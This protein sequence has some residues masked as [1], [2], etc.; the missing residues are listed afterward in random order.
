MRAVLLFSV[1]GADFACCKV[2]KLVELSYM[3]F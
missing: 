3:F 2:L 1:M